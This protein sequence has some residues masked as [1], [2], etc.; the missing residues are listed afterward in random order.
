MLLVLVVIF[1][2]F[3]AMLLVLVVIF[4][5]FVVFVAMLLSILL[6][7]VFKDVCN[8]LVI[9]TKSK[10]E[11]VKSTLSIGSLLLL[12]FNTSCLLLK[13]ILSI[14]LCKVFK[15]VCNPLVISTY[16]KEALFVKVSC[17][18]FCKLVISVLFEFIKFCKFVFVV[19]CDTSVLFKVVI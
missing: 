1:V 6:C 5:V 4:V 12:L 8:P 2:A 7:K 9:S 16:A 10:D 14:L 17:L 3:V 15:D 11:P 19:A 18:L 13:S